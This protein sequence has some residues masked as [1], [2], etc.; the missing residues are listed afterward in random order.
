[1]TNGKKGMRRQR[2]REAES[3]EGNNCG[4]CKVRMNKSGN[5]GRAYDTDAEHTAS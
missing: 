3:D 2:G 5:G 4:D 1:M